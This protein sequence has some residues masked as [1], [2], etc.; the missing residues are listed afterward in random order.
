MQQP[1]GIGAQDSSGWFSL[2]FVVAGAVGPASAEQLGWETDGVREHS[3]NPCPSQSQLQHQSKQP[4]KKH[5]HLWTVSKC[6][7][8]DLWPLAGSDMGL[9]LGLFLSFFLPFVFLLDIFK[10]NFNITMLILNIAIKNFSEHSWEFYYG[11]D[12]TIDLCWGLRLG[13]KAFS[14]WPRNPSQEPQNRILQRKKMIP[15]WLA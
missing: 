4:C 12:F 7:D 5:L 3:P 8:I 6:M 13:E 2:A 11:L 10:K 14:G 9:F 15:K 1:L